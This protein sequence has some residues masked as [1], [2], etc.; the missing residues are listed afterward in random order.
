MH[1]IEALAAGIRGAENGYVDV[2]RRGTSTRIT[3]YTN[4]EGTGFGATQVTLDANG[5]A[6]LFVNELAELYVY[7]SAGALVRRFVAGANATA[8]EVR[9]DSFTGVDY[10]TGQSAVNKPTTVAA[11][12]DLWNNSAGTSDFNVLVD[13]SAKTIKSA[14]AGSS[15]YY[16]VK[17]SAYG[18]VGDAATDD[19][20]AIQAAINAAASNGGTVFFPQG[21]YR[22]TAA[23]S[24]PSNVN[25]LG[26]GTLGTTLRLDHATENSITIST[27]GGTFFTSISG[28]WIFASQANSGTRVA[29]GAGRA[30]L[31]D[32]CVLGN[33]TTQNG[34]CVSGNSGGTVV[35]AAFTTFGL[36]GSSSRAGDV[37]KAH[38]Y[39][40]NVLLPTGAYSP[41]TGALIVGDQA[42]LHGV[43]FAAAVGA[44]SSGTYSLVTI[45]T[46]ASTGSITG[47]F[48]Q[49]NAS[50]TVTGIT[51]SNSSTVAETANTF[52][53]TITPYSY[54]AANLVATCLGTRAK[55]ASTA[56]VAG[57][58]T[59]RADQYGEVVASVS[60]NSA[61]VLT[62]SAAP[63]G[64]QFT[65]VID[66][67]FAGST[68]NITFA[69][70]VRGL[71]TET[72]ASGEVDIYR[73]LRESVDGTPQWLLMG[74]QRAL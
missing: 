13:G 4:F 40:C 72:L 46:A 28:M 32:N 7:S 10:T 56:A 71:T 59:I 66:N 64:S 26:V 6:T 11:I 25:L 8:V 16:N 3:W 74:A 41:T 63:L 38:F 55:A 30:V 44:P 12:L 37:Q 5:G 65:L 53:S 29:C 15:L 52:S 17:D 60:V 19:T 34:D 20:S 48:F 14:L 24:V 68:G 27:A 42:Q 9:S 36:S 23:L 69:A 35:A 62:L 50:A 21:N 61:L 45:S 2:F 22:H 31:I 18:A 33:N 54:T 39:G 49:G 1:C 51:W 57:N 47:C 70:D 43:T 58:T 67:D 73:F